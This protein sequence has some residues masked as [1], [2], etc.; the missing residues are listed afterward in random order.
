MTILKPRPLYFKYSLNCYYP[1]LPET[2]YLL[3]ATALYG[4]EMFTLTIFPFL[5]LIVKTL[6]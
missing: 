5:T 6:C 4:N 2:L 1:S 3:R